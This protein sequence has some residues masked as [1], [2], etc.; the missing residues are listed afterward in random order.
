MWDEALSAEQ[1]SALAGG[2]SAGEITSFHP[3]FELDLEDQ[4]RGANSS[5]YLRLPF[6][7]ESPLGGSSLTLRMKYNDGYV[8]WLNGVEISRR[9]APEAVSWNSSAAAERPDRLSF[10]LDDEQITGRINLLELGENVICFQGLNSAPDDPDFLL[11]PEIITAGAF[12]AER[13]YFTSPTPGAANTGGSLDFVEDVAISHEPGFYDEPL[14]VELACATPG[15]LIRFTTNGSAPSL[16]IGETYSRPLL[17]DDTTVLRVGA[18]R[19]NF[20]PSYID[21]RTYLFL[22]TPDGG[23]ILHQEA[24][25]PSPR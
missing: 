2:T 1:I 25:Q 18:F 7:L 8:A 21:T 15:A 22:D 5:V 14:E 10:S 24:R 12:V 3:L 17:V 6:T 23:G 9:N 13:R 4:L 19:E 16:D 11:V 20:E